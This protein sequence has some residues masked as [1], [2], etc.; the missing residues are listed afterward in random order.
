MDDLPEQ[1]VKKN[2]AVA[3][4]AIKPLALIRG[5]LHQGF[6]YLDTTERFARIVL[7]ILPAVFLVWVISVLTNLS[8]TNL[9]LWCVSLLII[10]ALNWVFNFNWWAGILF[11]FPS[12]RNPGERSTCRYLN[13][14]GER[15][16]KNLSL[17]GVM[18]FGSVSCG[19]WHNRS[20]LDIRLL[21]RPGLINGFSAVMFLLRER[22]IA[23]FLRQPL[24]I[25]LADD[26]D[27]LMKMRK[28]EPPIFLKKDDKRLD[29]IYPNGKVKRIERLRN[30]S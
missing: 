18:V 25:Y 30:D 15:L 21:R 3:G 13:T 28:D 29:E 20:D 6:S 4:G 5:F 8:G 26:I 9:R 11:A 16:K 10:H 19:Q 2:K 27:F 17:S 24:D 12:L 22:L 14:M 23:V 1:V 7:E